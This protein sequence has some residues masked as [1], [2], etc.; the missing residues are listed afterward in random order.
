MELFVTVWVS[1]ADTGWPTAVWTASDI[2]IY[3]NQPCIGSA[4]SFHWL[5]ES[6][7]AQPPS[8]TGEQLFATFM[9]SCRQMRQ[10]ETREDCKT[11][12]SGLQQLFAE[13]FTVRC[14]CK[15]MRHLAL[16]SAQ[17]VTM[18]TMQNRELDAISR[19]WLPPPPPCSRQRSNDDC[20]EDKRKD[21]QNCSVLYCVRQLCTVIHTYMNSS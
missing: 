12:S 14:I 4:A 8:N 3:L 20:L 6:T 5:K 11:V 18:Q 9:H 7:Y 17:L 2:I 1:I 19:L 15:W 13:I 21:Y 10:H 16:W